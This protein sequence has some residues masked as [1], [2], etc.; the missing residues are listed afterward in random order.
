MRS[1]LTILTF[2]LCALLTAPVQAE[3]TAPSAKGSADMEA[4]MAAYMKAAT[5][6]PSM[7]SS[8]SGRGHTTAR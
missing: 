4:I 7:P 3:E 1:T 8:P 6:V 5:T 2:V